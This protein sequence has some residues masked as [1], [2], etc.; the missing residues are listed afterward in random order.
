MKK[1][2]KG[3]FGYI[4]YNRKFA[5]IRTFIALAICLIIFFTGLFIYKSNKSAFSIIAALGCLP[6]GLS[7]VNLI[8]YMKAHP[9]SKA[10]Y[11]IIETHRGG[12]LIRYDLEMTSYDENYSI[13]AATVL[14][15]NVIC[16]TENKA[17]DTSN[18]EKHIRNQISQSGY[19]SYTV[20][21]FKDINAFCNRLD[22]LE[23]IRQSKNI[24]P[25][26]IEDSWVPGTVETCALVLLSISL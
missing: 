19:S 22:N 23:Q 18:C 24:D 20:K 9:C 1:V 14:D 17:L 6:T 21:V 12:L 10:A 5:T 3:N 25:Q 7:A 11:D 26:A 2:A 4:E 13:A 16:Y 8:M 15:K